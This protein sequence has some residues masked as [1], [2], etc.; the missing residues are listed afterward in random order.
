VNKK[1]IMWFLAGWLLALILPPTRITGM[2]KG[3]RS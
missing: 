2:L 1:L 3:K